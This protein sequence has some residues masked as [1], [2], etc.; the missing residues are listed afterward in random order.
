LFLNTSALEP[1]NINLR[2][3]QPG[4]IW[5]RTQLDITPFILNQ[6]EPAFSARRYGGNVGLTYK[7][8]RRSQSNITYT[9]EKVEQDIFDPES[10][11]LALYNKSAVTFGLLRDTSNPIFEPYSGW[12][13]SGQYTISGLGFGSDFYFYR[14]LFDLRHYLAV[15][16]HSV[17]AIRSRFGLI[18]SMD[19]DKFIPP[20]ERFYAGGSNS[21]RGW[22]RQELGPKDE[23]G[24][25]T[26]GS[27]LFEGSLEWRQRLI[28]SL[29][30]VAFLD[31]GNV[32]QEEFGFKLND[33]RYAVGFGV[34]YR[35]PIG[36]MRLDIARP[37][38][39]EETKW[40]WHLSV[41][42]AF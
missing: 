15:G 4:F 19:D 16:F 27:T 41:G 35:T 14:T 21:V 39:D 37:V 5:A 30:G 42:H 17:L 20:E 31:F 11:S 34:R 10:D 36:P 28:G 29:G 33:I 24:V 25:P 7:L 13:T 26:G 6:T 3:T 2:F 12:F 9:L 40:Q 32:W 38:F 23:L 22:L 18:K 8:D 1:Y